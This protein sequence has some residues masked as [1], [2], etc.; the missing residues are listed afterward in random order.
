M[1]VTSILLEYGVDMSPDAI[2]NEKIPFTG[3]HL[4]GM[5][6]EY[7][8]RLIPLPTNGIVLGRDPGCDII[9]ESSN[10]SRKHAEIR[11]SDGSTWVLRDLSSSNGS[12]CNDELITGD[13]VL[14]SDSLIRLDIFEFTFVIPEKSSLDLTDK[15]YR[16]HDPS[17]IGR[18]RA[19]SGQEGPPFELT[20]QTTTIGSG[21]FNDVVIEDPTVSTNHC[22]IKNDDGLY[23]VVDLKSTNGTWINDQRV[24][25]ELPMAF[26]DHLMVGKV[27]YLFDVVK[28]RD[29]RST[30]GKRRD[31]SMVF[32]LV[33]GMI[34]IIGGSIL[35]ALAFL[36]IFT[37]PTLKG[38][39]DRLELSS[40]WISQDKG[41]IPPILCDLDDDGAAE[42]LI[43][44]P[45]LRVACLEGSQG[46]TLWAFRTP[47]S[48]RGLTAVPAR[49]RQPA[50]A[51]VATDGG[52]TALDSQGAVRWESPFGD[53]PGRVLAAPCVSQLPGIGPVVALTT[54][55]GRCHIFACDNGRKIAVLGPHGISY[56]SAPLFCQLDTLP[57]PEVLLL[58]HDGS[59]RAQSFDGTPIWYKDAISDPELAPAAGDLDG[60]GHCEVIVIGRGR[61]QILILDGR[62][63][64]VLSTIDTGAPIAVQP[65]LADVDPRRGLELVIML[66]S[67]VLHVYRFPENERLLVCE[68]A[69]RTRP[70][71]PPAVHDFDNDGADDLACAYPGRDI[72]TISGRTGAVLARVAASGKLSGPI[73]LGELDGDSLLDVVVPFTDGRLETLSTNCSVEAGFVPWPSVLGAFDGSGTAPPN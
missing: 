50:L 49:G 57:G 1:C 72:V 4:I 61:Q 15:T 22:K 63:G 66:S 71:F 12:Y 55:A 58:G 51:L 47:A 32:F 59:L 17:L 16:Y 68:P 20:G 70:Q 48:V 53:F 42:I 62:R 24:E 65:V 69:R 39:T 23:T 36:R 34:A 40:A 28:R 18:L 60:D 10:V 46:R 30:L 56:L 29:D 2:R 26:G 64:A 14:A 31:S 43:A 45:G 25:R 11:Q 8:D 6:D 3:P 38:P 9:I 35:C 13:R 5:S 54:S 19:I 33:T 44:G 21:S 7:L 27:A 67:G 41:S 73:V 52:I 37:S